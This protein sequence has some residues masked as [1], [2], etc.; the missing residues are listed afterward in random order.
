MSNE[1]AWA[2]SGRGS[3]YQGGDGEAIVAAHAHARH[4][5]GLETQDDGQDGGGHGDDDGGPD[6][7]NQARHA[8]TG[9][10]TTVT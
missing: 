1:H 10:A 4:A 6:I 2:G 5:P 9:S 7:G 3:T 8:G